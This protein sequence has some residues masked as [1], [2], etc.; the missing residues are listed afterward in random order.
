MDRVIVRIQWK[1][2]VLWKPSINSACDWL[3]L[4]KFGKCKRKFKKRKYVEVDDYF[5]ILLNTDWMQQLQSK[6]V[7]AQLLAGSVIIDPKTTK[8]LW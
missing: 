5:S 3:D 2:L 8:Q 1:L 4:V 6:Y 7:V